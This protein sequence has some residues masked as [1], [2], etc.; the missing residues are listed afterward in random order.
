MNRR[1]VITGI[2]VISGSGFTLDEFWGNVVNGNS[3]ADFIT[4][5]N[6]DK[7]P[8]RIGAEVTNFS[9]GE[10]TELPKA[11][12]YDRSVQ[13]SLAAA[14][15]AYKDAD[16][17]QV[18]VD[19]TRI[20]AIEGSTISA[21]ESILKANASLA[22]S[23]KR[24]HPYNVVGG[25]F[26]EGSSAL[27]IALKLQG[28]AMTYCSGCSSGSDALGYARQII[29][30]DEADIMLAGGS[31][32]ITELLHSGFC[33]LKTMSEWQGD[34]K[35]AMRPFDKNRDGFLL[36]EGAAFLVLEELSHAKAR[37]AR[38][39][40]EIVSHGR[41]SEAFHSTDP[42]PEGLG[43]QRAIS[44]ALRKASQKK[45]RIQYVN[46]HASATPLNDPTE[47]HAIEAV[48]SGH[49][50]KLQIGSSKPI[51]GHMMGAAG[52]ME[53][54]VTILSIFHS[55]IPPSINLLNR[56]PKCKLDYVDSRRA[57]PVEHALCLN[58]GFG[59]RYS[60]LYFRKL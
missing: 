25:Y 48:F 19:P 10:F 8:V 35:M 37:G 3:A 24:I 43:Y 17:N 60:C 30:D 33:K 26:G 22:G 15:N 54:V 50:K 49:A 42:H 16:I 23:Y 59:G 12:R 14:T 47:S 39:Y 28:H 53:S 34:P 7:L 40:A 38:I 41:V 32:A 52:A 46:A 36:G 58:A 21:M 31:E 57:F 29:A 9:I 20:G 4:G 44:N 18:N 1:V 5:F 51:F 13:F 27:S 55:E 6:A 45:E 2:G 56:D 11:G